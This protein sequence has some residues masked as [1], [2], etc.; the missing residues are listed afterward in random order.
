M[1][2]LGQC[3]GPTGLPAELLSCNLQVESNGTNSSGTASIYASICVISIGTGENKCTTSQQPD[4]NKSLQGV[5][6][7]NNA[8]GVEIG[9]ELKGITSTIQESKSLCK[10]LGVKGGQKTGKVI[11]E[12]I[13]ETEGQK[14]V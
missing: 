13:L 11:F 2:K 7:I 10:T 12:G 5:K 14:V 8:A 9:A 1:T 3:T 4:G 6:L